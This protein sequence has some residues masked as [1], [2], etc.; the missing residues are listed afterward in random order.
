SLTALVDEGFVERLSAGRKKPYALTDLGRAKASS[1]D[2]QQFEQAFEPPRD[3]S[4]ARRES[5]DPK[6]YCGLSEIDQAVTAA[7]ALADG[8]DFMTRLAKALELEASDSDAVL[9]RCR[10]LCRDDKRD[11]VIDA[12]GEV[13]HGLKP[14]QKTVRAWMAEHLPPVIGVDGLNQLARVH[15]SD[16][17]GYELVINAD[18]LGVVECLVAL[19]TRRPA[20]LKL[21]EVKTSTGELEPEL[22]SH[23][24]VEMTMASL[25]GEGDARAITDAEAERCFLGD[26]AKRPEFERIAKSAT[27]RRRL[28]KRFERAP[29]AREF[30]VFEGA[31]AEYARRFQ[32]ALM[33]RKISIHIVLQES[34]SEQMAEIQA[35][36]KEYFHWPLEDEVN[37]DAKD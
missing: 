17:E 9:E 30:V 18:C 6:R 19:A 20:E 23:H 35:W 16:R 27:P 33:A 24:R 12:L 3:S 14:D 7:S 15:A 8:V 37:D 34:A 31:D 28:K 13:L 25:T 10:T 5:L 22:D 29:K 2:S 11:H 21:A 32:S 1:S 36:L 4:R 26:Y